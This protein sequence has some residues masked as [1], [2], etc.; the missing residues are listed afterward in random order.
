MILI[1]PL[2][3]LGTRFR[4]KG[5]NVPKPL[6]N[7]MGKPVLFWLLDNLDLTNIN[8]LV[9][10]YNFELD[11]YRFE[12]LLIKEY[13]NINFIFIKLEK[14]TEG[15]AETIYKA[16]QQL[17]LDDCPILCVDGDNFYTE[18][19]I[20][21]WNGDNS[22]FVFN[23]S[24]SE[25]IYSYVQIEDNN[26][27]DIK[28]KQKIS[29]FASTGAYG[30][31]SW[32][33]LQEYCLK[34]ITNEIK[35]KN[36]YYTSTVIKEMIKD[37]HLFLPKIVNNDSYICLGTPLHVRIFC[38][39]YPKVSALTSINKIQ[40]KRFCFD[41]DNTLV[42]F[43]KVSGDYTTVEPIE[44]NIKI[45][46]YL[47]NFGNTII[48][49]TARRM[50]THGCNLGK[51]VADIGKITF[52]TLEK[53]DIPY[54]ELYFGKPY[55][56]FYIDD[57]A[58]SSYD[59]LEKELGYYRSDIKPRDFNQL[60]SYSIQIYKKTSDDLAG[61]IHYYNNIPVEIKDLFPIM[62]NYDTVN[63][64][65]YD[66]EKLNGIPISKLYLA[67]ELT[68]V[69]L[70]H[71]MG[72]IN[73]IHNCPTDSIDKQVN[74]YSNYS[75]KL[76]KRYENYNYS[77]FENS[78]DIYKKILNKLNN[79]EESQKGSMSIIHGDPVL[80][81]ILINNFGK[82]KFIDMRGKLDDKLTLLGDKMYDWAKLYQ[83]LLG[84]DE[85]L[86]NTKINNIYKTK[87]LD[88]FK[89]QFLTIT[90]NNFE[91]LQIITASLLFT[92][93]PLHDNE[94]CTEYFELINKIL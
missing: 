94:K 32:K 43:P 16:L 73:R 68:T 17:T 2:G 38:N 51:V 87:M 71:I 19:I 39:N 22:V 53:F 44:K 36:E 77:Q 41:F 5:Y 61:E 6:I 63:N 69:N 79:Y 20:E 92:L 11:K 4:E 26:I 1:I 9:I 86:E 42:T 67:E 50:K 48:I 64:K 74:I 59:D 30:F 29:N 55:A 18:N 31:N 52:D 45:L 47:K 80:T 56:N 84:Y 15:S 93:I 40:P 90:N 72:S 21:K 28:E 83:S 10:P 49:H 75:K 46:R 76:T 27:T 70:D 81:N 58:V 65:W 89:K 3:G 62:I 14:N 8:H 54:D 85:I 78:N 23:D 57:L 7:V 37:K 88:H 25:E 13:P 24:S 33:K 82:I 91:D 12:D 66:M 35:Q 34:I 60:S